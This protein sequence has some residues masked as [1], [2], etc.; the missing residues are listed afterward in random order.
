M[1]VASVSLSISYRRT[2]RCTE[3]QSLMSTLVFVWTLL[4]YSWLILMLRKWSRQ[5]S[6][7]GFGKATR[8]G[9]FSLT[10]LVREYS[11]TH[12]GDPGAF[13]VSFSMFGHACWDAN[14]LLTPLLRKYSKTRFGDPGAFQAS[15]SRFGQATW[16]DTF[17]LTILLRKYSEAH[18]SD[19]GP[20][21]RHFRVL[22]R[23]PGMASSY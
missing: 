14:V 6:F 15:F 19:H 16:D 23:V 13:K 8:A 17:F 7:S 4:F 20:S 2:R 21:S 9:N 3:N 10:P 5:V 22:V 18:F 1:I 11:K 12:F